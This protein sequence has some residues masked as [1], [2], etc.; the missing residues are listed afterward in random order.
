MKTVCLGALRPL[1]WLAAADF[2][3]SGASS[4]VGGDPGSAERVALVHLLTA[5]PAV[6]TLTGPFDSV[7]SA[8][9]AEA[10]AVAA[11]DLGHS[12]GVPEDLTL[13]ATEM[14]ERKYRHL[15]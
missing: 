5:V 6:K 10:A 7:G 2:A 9:A 8:D 1:D 4:P 13:L 11:G 15:V 12:W 14:V 3:G